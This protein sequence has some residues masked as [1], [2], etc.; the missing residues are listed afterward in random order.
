MKFT[1]RRRNWK[2]LA[3]LSLLL[4]AVGVAIA[5]GVPASTTSVSESKTVPTL[6]NLIKQEKWDDALQYCHNHKDAAIPEINTVL[7][8]KNLDAATA[9]FMYHCLRQIRTSASAML[10]AKDFHGGWRETV[11]GLIENPR[12]EAYPILKARL[13]SPQDERDKDLL[14]TM[15]QMDVPV[16]QR[17]TDIK[18]YLEA[19][20]YEVRQGAVL[21]LALLDDPG[22]MERMVHEL[23]TKRRQSQS[24]FLRVFYD[25]RAWRIP[26]FVPVLIPVLNDPMP[27]D[28]IGIR[29]YPP[30]GGEQ[31]MTPDEE[32]YCRARDYALNIIVKTLNLDLP[33]KIQDQTTYTKEQRDLVKQ[34][35]RDLG[36][37]VTDEPYPVTSP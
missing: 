20:Y 14:L 1:N 2:W 16:E 27:L 11:Y 8:T 25:F 26:K 19:R 36:Y 22:S 28:D 13:K 15:A 34:K 4:G 30:G 12:P 7:D 23:S 24:D 35:L 37:T 9:N 32:R 33:F 17:V 31:S 29:M 21:S 3:F 18:P 5:Q 10:M 6:E